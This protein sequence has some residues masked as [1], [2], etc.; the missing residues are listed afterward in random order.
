MTNSEKLEAAFLECA[1]EDTEAALQLITGM[2]VGLTLEYMRR[3]GF[4]THKEIKMEGGSRVITIHALEEGAQIMGLNE[5]KLPGVEEAAQRIDE[6][7]TATGINPLEIDWVSVKFKLKELQKENELFKSS[8]MTEV[9]ARDILNDKA[10]GADKRTVEEA[11]EEGCWD[12]NDVSLW[13]IDELKALAWFLEKRKQNP[14]DFNVKL[15]G[16]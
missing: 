9:E 10:Y 14:E 8:Q 3:R 5:Q 1:A 7:I 6:L 11:I 2:F 4:E 12:H 16:Y 15:R 13:E